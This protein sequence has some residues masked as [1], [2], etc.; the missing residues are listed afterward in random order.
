M[1]MMKYPDSIVGVVTKVDPKEKP[2]NALQI[3]VM[4]EAADDT[5]TMGVS[6]EGISEN[7]K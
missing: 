4:K 6:E 2:W 5:K 3:K 1:L 7:N